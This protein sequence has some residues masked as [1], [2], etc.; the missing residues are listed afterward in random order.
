M[1]VKPSLL[2]LFDAIGSFP[3]RMGKKKK[4]I[5]QLISDMSFISPCL[6]MSPSPTANTKSKPEP[7]AHFTFQPHI[8]G[9]ALC[10]DNGNQKAIRAAFSRATIRFVALRS[11]LGV[12]Q[13]K[14]RLH[15]AM[16]SLR[17]YPHYTHSS[18]S[19][20]YA[21]NQNPISSAP[22]AIPEAHKD[23]STDCLYCIIDFPSCTF[24]YLLKASGI[25]VLCSDCVLAGLS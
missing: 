24:T 18:Q 23:P 10:P 19:T 3:F 8:P 22:L 6:L 25:F 15:P 17:N 11:R 21:G 4:N 5:T 14:P 20:G 7:N 1:F 9:R 12:E 13:S 16:S 2:Q